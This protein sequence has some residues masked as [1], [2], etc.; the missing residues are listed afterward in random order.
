MPL[1]DD[2]IAVHGGCNCGAIRYRAD[3]PA[4]AQRPLHPSHARM[5]KS[6]PCRLP[7]IVIDHCNDCRRATGAV[8]PLW[9]CTPL[10]FITASFVLRSPLHSPQTQDSGTKEMQIPKKLD[11]QEERTPWLPASETFSRNSKYDTYLSM[12]ESSPLRTRFFCSRCGTSLAYA[13]VPIPEGWVDMLDLVL[14]SVDRE[15]LETKALAPERH[16]WWDCGIS[17]VH[18]ASSGYGNL[19][20][21]PLWDL[22]EIVKEGC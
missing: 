22:N 19:V 4:L 7:M 3:I 8:L 2:P 14:G 15:D 5:S 13:V 21:H 10:A 1:P 11:E 12:Y 17:W 18:E 6:D 9:L 16:L 20:K